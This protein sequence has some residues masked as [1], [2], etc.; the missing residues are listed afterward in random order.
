VLL[1]HISSVYICQAGVNQLYGQACWCWTLGL[2]AGATS[3]VKSRWLCY[4]DEC[5]STCRK[6]YFL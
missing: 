2:I 3:V 4:F 1:T 5:R 6:F